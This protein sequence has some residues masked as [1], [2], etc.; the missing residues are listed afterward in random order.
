MKLTREN[1][2]S[3][4]DQ[5]NETMEL[6]GIDHTR[7]LQ[8]ALLIEEFLLDYMN[9]DPDADFRLHIR[10]HKSCISIVLSVRCE[11]FDI[12]KQHENVISNMILSEMDPSP[13]W[14]YRFGRNKIILMPGTILSDFNNF[15]FMYRH[16]EKDKKIFARALVLRYV[17]I[18][19]EIL[20][21]ILTASIIMA[22]SDSEYRRIAL[23]AILIL[24][25]AFVSSMLT[26]AFN[27]LIRKFYSS[28]VKTMRV[29]VVENVLQVKTEHIVNKGTGV[30]ISRMLDETANVIDGIDE[31]LSENANLLNIISLLI[32]FA[33]VSPKMLLFELIVFVIYSL[34]QR[35]ETRVFNKD[36]RL[37]TASNEKLFSISGEMVRAHRDIRLLHCEDSFLS[38]Q[39]RSV[40]ETADMITQKRVH[41]MN[42]QLAR[43]QFVSVANFLY[44]ALLALLMIKEGLAPSVALVLFNYN[45]RFHSCLSSFSN[46]IETFESL[47]LSSELIN[48]L[49][50]S[51]DF[52]KEIFGTKRLKHV[53]GE[54]EL[55][56]ISFSYCDESGHRVSVLRGLN[57]HIHPGQSVAIVGRSGCG[58]STVLS[59]LTRLYDLDRGCILLDG[60]NIQELDR[61]TLRG[62]IGMVSQMPYIFN[63]S[64]R[65]NMRVVKEDMT[66]EEMEKACRLAC[67][68]DD[69]MAFPDGYDTVI[70]EGGVTLSGGQKQRLAIAR[71]LVRDYP[72]IILDEAT[73]A[74][75]NITQA[76]VIDAIETVHGKKTIIMVAH[77]LSTVIN[78]EKL[79]FLSDG[80]IQAE[81]SHLELLES[82]EEYR[83]L[84]EEENENPPDALL[85]T[86]EICA[87]AQSSP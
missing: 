9:L 73:S 36:S 61:D 58:K 28:I 21:P 5:A 6:Y 82:C 38:K 69:I 52:A 17:N 37:C 87:G 71:C 1:I 50:R 20:D 77:R 13:I 62:N 18:G 15:R 26:Y 83:K 79:F 67:I 81:G 14:R 11:P 41:S 3:S 39:K 78:C 25:Q 27:R 22:Y 48:Q 43:T 70:G 44:M 59:L 4:V 54:I 76:Q 49:F 29:E 46:L 42:F 23:L 33:F 34:I 47:S 32:A 16:F 2:Q 35:A 74:L 85:S 60:N 7:R 64:V 51:R 84:Y 72:V 68:H 24:F 63:M 75:D 57:M 45:I 66:D 80:K 30:F 86:P 40:E 55:R 19:L 10:K 53:S 31:L 8:Y 65:E 12:L 56:N